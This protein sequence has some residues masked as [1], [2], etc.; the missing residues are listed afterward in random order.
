MKVSAGQAKASITKLVGGTTQFMKE[1]SKSI[2]AQ[3]SGQEKWVCFF[4]FY[5]YCKIGTFGEE[6]Q[7]CKHVLIDGQFCD[8]WIVFFGS[9]CM[10]LDILKGGE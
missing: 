1:L 2:S 7:L 6:V 9:Y 3:K 4:F 5:Y 10:D 8:A